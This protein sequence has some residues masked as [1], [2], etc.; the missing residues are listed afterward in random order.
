MNYGQ[1][2]AG[3]TYTLF[4]ESD[5]ERVGLVP[6]FI[7]EIYAKLGE[8][9]SCENASYSVKASFFEIYK[10]RIH[11]LLV[12]ETAS[13]G[14]NLRENP[15]RG[16]FI[17]N[18]SDRAFDNSD[19]LGEALNTAMQKRKINETSMNARSSR[20]H[21]VTTIFVE[22]RTHLECPDPDP[23]KA[24]DRVQYEVIKRAKLIFIDLAGSE[25]QALNTND[26]LQEGCSIN[27]SLSVLQHVVASIGKKQSSQFVH[28][29]DSK[30]NK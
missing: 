2:S 13:Q 26:I 20:S 21:F 30:L 9:S 18:L 22:T 14:L 15:D 25:R 1:T 11:D 12:E 5:E 24:L 3:K 16:V 10:E 6:R 23:A 8:I 4:G 28:Y 29:R 17:E 19:L 27:K 7:E